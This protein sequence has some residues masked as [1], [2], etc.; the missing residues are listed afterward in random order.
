MTPELDPYVVL[1][2]PQQATQ[3]E[4]NRAYRR[5]V[6]RHHPDTRPDDP[7]PADSPATLE[8]VLAAYATLRDPSRRAEYDRRHAPRTARRP[9][10]PV[11]YAEPDL[12]T[13][14]PIRVGPVRYHGPAR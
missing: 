11:R 14:F 1:G 7:S 13:E 8:Q 5:L 2:V 10:P 4:I 6:R 9:A 3:D 12:R